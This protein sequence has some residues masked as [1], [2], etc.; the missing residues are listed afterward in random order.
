MNGT[1]AARLASVRFRAL[2]TD[3]LVMSS[4]AE[5][6]AVSLCAAVA[7]YERAFSRFLPDSELARLTARA[8]EPFAVSDDMFAV[9]E[10]AMRFWRQTEGIFDPLIRR[11]LEAAGYDHT[12]TAVP[13]RLPGAAPAPPARSFTFGDVQLDSARRTVTLPPGARLDL[14]GV[15]KGW[16][17]DRLG[18]LLAPHGPYL[19]DIGGDITAAGYGP[20]GA[21]G[22][23]VAVA[24]PFRI[25]DDLSLLRLDGIGIATSSTSKRRWLRAGELFH[26]LIDP[27]TGRPADTGVVQVTVLAATTMEADVYAKTALILDRDAG[28]RWL[29][30][31]SLAGLLV[32]DDASVPTSAWRRIV[33]PTAA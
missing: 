2:G 28:Y 8:G 23:L 24:D 4:A 9:L 14:G 18:E 1:T 29:E 15:A 21:P 17:V 16:I 26:H 30:H 3:V 27:R 19:V 20:D 13:R 12:F 25:S 5:P 32:T 10:H 33:K 7:G 11:E 6:L 22:W 31:R